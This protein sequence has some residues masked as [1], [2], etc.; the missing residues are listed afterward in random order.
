MDERSARIER[1]FEVPI[2][3]AA[4]LVVPVI[5]VEQSGVAEPWRTIAGVLNWMIWS[6]F[7]AELVVMLAVVR[8][9]WAWLRAHPI[10]AAVVLLT[11][12]FLP[13]SLQAARLLRLLRV[14]RLLA[15]AKY[16]R[17]VFSLEG[18]R[19]AFILATLTAL[20]GGWAYSSI[21]TANDATVWDGVWWAVSTMTTVGYGDEF[22]LTTLGRILGIGLMLLGIGF[23]AILT[24]AVAERFL[25][26]HIEE[27]E[28]QVTEELE[29]AEAEV[30]AELRAIM[31][32]LQVLE[33]RLSGRTT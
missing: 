31:E 6:A 20:G 17:V 11:P 25:A 19:Y 3:I 5:V 18:V 30:L 23:I 24:G 10:E 4:L 27:S 9:R 8:D 15:L 32:R 28:E 29:Q 22:P 33:Q 7:A 2:L 26:T 14:I 21:E 12:P 13:A 16:A 1:A